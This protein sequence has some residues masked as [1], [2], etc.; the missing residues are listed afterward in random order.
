MANSPRYKRT[1]TCYSQC[2]QFIVFF[3][4]ATITK[5]C[6]MWTVFTKYLFSHFSIMTLCHVNVSIKKRRTKEK[7]SKYYTTLC[8][9]WM[10]KEQRL[11]V[12]LRIMAIKRSDS[13]YKH[14]FDRFSQD[15]NRVNLSP[16]YF[17]HSPDGVSKML[18]NRE[19]CNLPVVFTE[20]VD[21]MGR[22]WRTVLFFHNSQSLTE[23]LIVF[24][25]FFS[26]R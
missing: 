10:W 18:R 3:L 8:Y 25:P 12:P 24:F 23:L 4:C 13:Q 17:L 5:R 22:R 15:C 19:W 6:C 26:N 9:L 21:I 14:I 11:Q 2:Q 16:V 20:G 1:V 7:K